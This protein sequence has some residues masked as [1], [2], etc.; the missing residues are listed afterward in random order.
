MDPTEQKEKQAKKEGRRL[1]SVRAGSRAVYNMRLFVAD[2]EPNSAL[3][4][5]NLDEICST[6]LKGNVKLETID[7]FEDFAPAIEDNI[8]VTPALVIDSPM[9]LK[10]YGNLQDKDKVLSALELI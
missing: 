6:Y 3:A 2:N 10:I 5:K 8:L 7:V 4:R 1:E 9:K